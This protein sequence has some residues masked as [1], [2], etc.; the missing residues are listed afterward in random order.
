MSALS[1]L[2]RAGLTNEQRVLYMGGNPQYDM[3]CKVLPL[4]QRAL[5]EN[6]AKDFEDLIGDAL[7]LF[8]GED[9]KGD[10]QDELRR[11]EILTRYRHILVDEWQDIDDSQYK[12][13]VQMSRGCLCGVGEGSDTHVSARQASLFV[14]G[15]SMQTIYSWRGAD[16]LNFAKFAREYDAASSPVPAGD[17]GFSTLTQ[18][19]G[20]KTYILRENY[21]SSAA[22]ISSAAGLMQNGGGVHG[23]GLEGES[24]DA[25]MGGFSDDTVIRMGVPSG[26]FGV[27]ATNADTNVPVKAVMC[28]DDESQAKF[29][30]QQVQWWVSPR[31]G[32]VSASEVAVMYR[33]HSQ[34]QPIELA[35]MSAGIPFRLVNALSTADR[36]DVKDVLAYLRV[37]ANP[38]DVLAL[39]RV[40][41]YPPRGI[42]KSTCDKFFEGVLDLAEKEEARLAAMQ[43]VPVLT[44][45]TS[46]EADLSALS[47][48]LPDE[49]DVQNSAAVAAEKRRRLRLQ[50]GA[51]QLLIEIGDF[52]ES[53][54]VTPKKKK[55]KKLKTVESVEANLLRQQ[56]E[57]DALLRALNLTRRQGKA[58]SGAGRLFRSLRDLTDG[59]EGGLEELLGE[60][61]QQSG[62]GV[63]IQGSESADD[64]DLIQSATREGQEPTNIATQGRVPLPNTRKPASLKQLFP[65]RAREVKKAEFMSVAA[66]KRRD[67]EL[68]M[69]QLYAMAR[70]R[71]DEWEQEHSPEDTLTLGKW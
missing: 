14:V 10:E 59:W 61:L 69:D 19:T 37:L 2:K 48:R 50:S 26:G 64:A 62:L 22:I 13:L 21:R 25:G 30:A 43:P 63:V 5:R 58:L 67:K 16:H 53:V 12:L 28:Y 57:C 49:T 41:N 11:Q 23:G 29:I 4:Y 36:K 9:D 20:A 40:I 52:D 47:G 32:N 56:E 6:N 54:W 15:D 65:S 39:Q 44:D 38:R 66:R 55:E 7:S 35:M 45:E 70:L 24:G 18:K 46:Y 42:G 3:A 51:L 31:G 8:R 34:A 17:A 68:L 71:D 33:R 27:G 60:V 1:K